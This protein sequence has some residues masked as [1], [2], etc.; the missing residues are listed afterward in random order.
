MFIDVRLDDLFDEKLIEYFIRK[1]EKKKSIGGLDGVYPSEF[2]SFW[3]EHGNAI[4]N[5]I[6]SERYTPVPAE[7]IL[8]PKPGSKK[9][10]EL[11]VPCVV[12]GMIMKEINYLLNPYYEKMFSDNSF[13]FRPQ[14]GCLRA[15]K[16]VIGI[17]NE[18]YDYIISIDLASFF[19]TVN[20]K[21]LFQ[22]MEKDFEDE[23]LLRLI[24][25]YITTKVIYGRHIYRNYIGVPQGS[26]LS[27]LL[28]NVY[29]NEFDQMMDKLGY[30]YIRYAD[31]IVLFAQNE[32]EK[33]EIYNVASNILINDLKLKINKDKTII[34]KGRLEYLGYEIRKNNEEKY[35]FYISEKRKKK[36][37]EKMN[38][39]MKKT[40][41]T[42]EEWLNR[43]G[44]FNRG[45]LNYYKYADR[46]DTALLTMEADIYQMDCIIKK[47]TITESN[48]FITLSDWWDLLKRQ[49][50][51]R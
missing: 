18:G 50:E 20:H 24:K 12:D 9:K 49:E 10:R 38:R 22:I 17:M 42:E 28:A 29:L 21:K 14:K 30:R 3:E 19:D 44:A 48:S 15:L 47:V 33:K 37:Y 11:I 51:G 13:G 7:K 27:P 6:L 2:R 39:N 23:R 41:L 34:S 25:M 32:F 8:I 36:V 1:T 26:A 31:D 40:S 5:L 16:Y 45:W 46:Y 43:L 35:N 4:K